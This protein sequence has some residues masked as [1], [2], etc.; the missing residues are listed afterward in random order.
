MP[1]GVEEINR[2]FHHLVGEY[3]VKYAGPELSAHEN[4][5]LIQHWDFFK[6]SIAFPHTIKVGGGKSIVFNNENQFQKYLM[7]YSESNYMWG[8]HQQLQIT[9]N[10]YNVKINILTVNAEGEGSILKEPFSLDY[11]LLKSDKTEMQ[12]MWLLYSNGNHYDALI[13]KDHPLLTL[14]TLGEME[15]DANLNEA[16]TEQENKSEEKHYKYKE[17]TV[18]DLKKKL[19]ESEHSKLKVENMY[20]ELETVVKNLQEEKDRLK[21]NVKD[22][23]EYIET[24][25][26]N[27]GGKPADPEKENA[28]IVCNFLCQAFEQTWLY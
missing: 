22:L 23:T 7:D 26:N 13:K 6:E 27:E 20:K 24:K 18:N 1:K 15:Q 25:E 3:K 2:K 14:G 4:E 5:Y 9:A 21:I 28:R 8:D 17:D 11:A 19:K 16:A 10:R 12:E